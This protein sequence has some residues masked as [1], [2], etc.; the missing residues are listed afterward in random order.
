MSA[1]DDSFTA[2]I[3]DAYGLCKLVAERDGD[4]V[5]IG[6]ESCGWRQEPTRITEPVSAYHAARLA[7][8]IVAVLP[9]DL[10]GIVQT[11]LARRGRV[12]GRPAREAIGQ[13]QV[14]CR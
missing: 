9:D 8:W 5:A 12:Q 10:L 11:A 2:P 3:A 13:C 6:T 1:P 14:K 4:R 7:A